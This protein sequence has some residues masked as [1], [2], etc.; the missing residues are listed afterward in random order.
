MADDAVRAFPGAE[1]F[2]AYAKGGRGG[3]V[4]VVTTLDDYHPG[5]GPREAETRNE[6]GEVIR[7]AQPAVEAESP[8][9]GSL[10]A[11]LNAEGPRTVVFAVG[12][13]IELKAPL[14]IREPFL[15]LAGQSAPGGGICLKNFG[16]SISNT[17]DVVIRY[18]RIRPG[19]EE[20]LALDALSIGGCQNVVIDH[21]SASWGIDETLSVSGAGSNNV[22]VQWC[23]ITE[24]LLD[25]HHPKGR[26]GMGSLLRTNGDVSFHHNLFAHHNSRSPRP[27]TYGEDRSI[28]L[29]FRNNAI[30]NWGATPGYSAADPVRMNYVGNYLKPGPSSR[31]REKAFYIGG[32]TTLIFAKANLLV[33][34]DRRIEGGWELIADGSEVNRTDEPYPMGAIETESPEAAMNAVLAHGGASLPIRDAVDERIVTEVRTGAGTIVNSQTE[35]G[36]WPNLDTGEAAVDTD[37]DGM[38]GAWEAEHGLNP[39]DGTDHA[40]DSDGDGYSNL[41]E[42]LNGLVAEFIAQRK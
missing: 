12:G 18:L 5:Q 19:D 38:P 34:G 10:R 3:A 2:G 32:D 26:H 6:T 17:H 1:G 31:K 36:G 22:T 39:S 30:Y 13:T 28:L 8:I 20:R 40:G 14:S 11:G 21:C 9:P 15:T 27:G 29:D 41:E 4:Y 16:L 33:D 24:S 37:A 35:V 42:Y 25:S 23:F 7:P